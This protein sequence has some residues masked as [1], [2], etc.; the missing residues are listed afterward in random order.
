MKGFCVL[1]TMGKC[2]SRHLFAYGALQIQITITDLL[3]GTLLI[4]AYTTLL[5]INNS[6]P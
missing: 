5:Q 6:W 1:R 4:N 3:L 2:I